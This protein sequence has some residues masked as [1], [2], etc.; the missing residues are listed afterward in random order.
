MTWTEEGRPGQI[1]LVY[2]KDYERK[3]NFTI[4]Q[5]GASVAFYSQGKPVEVIEAPH[6]AESPGHD[7][8]W[9]IGCVTFGESD[10]GADLKMINSFVLRPPARRNTYCKEE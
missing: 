6:F 10:A 2:V 3:D 4:P 9:L 8:F 1:F 7:R 5:S